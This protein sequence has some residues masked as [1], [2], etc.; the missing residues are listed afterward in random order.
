MKTQLLPLTEHRCLR[1]QGAEARDFLQGQLSNDLRLLTPTQ[2]QLGSYNSPKGRVLAVLHLR[3]EAPDS[4]ITEVHES[5]ADATL[6]RLRMFVLRTRVQVSLA[7]AVHTLGV[8]GDDAASLLR[9]LDLPVPADTALGCAADATRG[10]QVL[11]R[12]GTAP[13]FSI[14]GRAPALGELFAR[15]PADYRGDCSDLWRAADIEAGVPTVFAA[16]REHF[17]PQS[18]DLDLLGGISFDKGCYTGQ[19][20][21]ARLHYLGQ[22]KRRLFVC[23]VEGSL[24]PAGTEVLA[25]A[26]GVAAGEVVDAV[27]SGRGIVASVALQLTHARSADLRLGDGSPVLVMHPAHAERQTPADR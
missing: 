4:V 27:A 18:I 25:G 1:I 15:V 14:S 23:H 2:A 20:I 3:E 21:V 17:V 6:S 22:V 19:E 24:P 26:S 10:L 9:D 12:I 7:D 11:R 16:T 5:V 13:R 8:V